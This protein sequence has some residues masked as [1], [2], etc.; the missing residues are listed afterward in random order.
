[1]ASAPRS[2][3]R[4]SPSSRRLDDPLG[5]AKSLSKRTDTGK[6]G[7]FRRFTRDWIAERGDNLDIAWLKDES[8]GATDK[9]PEP[10]V[11][12]QEAMTELEGALEELRGILEE[13]GEEVEA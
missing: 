2:R 13:L 10:A 12:A 11:L 8:E 1:L 7:R 9:L 5:S 4:I 3:T 6:S